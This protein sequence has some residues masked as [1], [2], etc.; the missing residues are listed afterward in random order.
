MY[1][2]CYSYKI[3]YKDNILVSDCGQAPSLNNSDVSAPVTTYLQYAT[4]TCHPG[5]DPNVTDMRIMCEP[6]AWDNI[7]FWCIPRGK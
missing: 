1:S 7:T 3:F 4:Y 5:H 2:L 6:F